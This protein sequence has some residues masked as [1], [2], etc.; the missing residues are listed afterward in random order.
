MFYKY[1]YYRF[2]QCSTDCNKLNWYWHL[3]TFALRKGIVLEEKHPPIYVGAVGCWFSCSAQRS[4]CICWIHYRWGFHSNHIKIWTY[5]F[6]KAI[7]MILMSSS[8]QHIMLRPAPWDI[9]VPIPWKCDEIF[10]K[11][12]WGSA[13]EYRWNEW[14]LTVQLSNSC[15]ILD[16]MIQVPTIGTCLFCLINIDLLA[17]APRH[18]C[19]WKRGSI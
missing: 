7:R 5:T 17:G 4:I 6:T 10:L 13:T 14:E 9:Q 15:I 18:A 12:V 1:R 19:S 8:S 2:W 16:A 11:L 3:F